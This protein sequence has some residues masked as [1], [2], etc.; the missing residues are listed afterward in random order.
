M[1]KMNIDEWQRRGEYFSYQGLSIYWQ[2]RGN[3][4]APTLLLIH[5][6]PTSSWDW[7]KV[8]DYLSQSFRVITLDMLG[9]GFSDKPSKFDYSIEVQAD[10]CELLLKK[11]AVK[12]YAIVAHDYGDTVAQ[13]LIARQG[14]MPNATPISA[15][16]F[17]NGGI[18]PEAHKALRIQKLMLSPLGSLIA[19][20]VNFKRF[21]Q[22]LKR[23]CHQPISNAELES[24]WQLININDGKKVMHKL[25]HYISERR[26]NR[27]RWVGALAKSNL[28][29][30]LIAGTQDPI[31]GASMIKR[32]EQSLPTAAV[33]R[34]KDAGHYP[35]LESPHTV[36]KQAQAFLTMHTCNA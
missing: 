14:Q 6:F 23:I 15:C 25:I 4:D 9:F 31:S 5:G 32:F 28:P 1:E 7:H 29:L 22:N 33:I 11:L 17:L 16:C 2:Q 12:Q 3:V 24:Q 26:K 20:A 21:S 19:K 35:Q 34:L 13:E 18:F 10:I 27:A 36:A 8:M 30:C